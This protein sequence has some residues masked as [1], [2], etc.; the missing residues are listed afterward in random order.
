MARTVLRRVL[1]GTRWAVQ[2]LLALVALAALIAWPWSYAHPGHVQAWRPWTV[3]AERLER[4]WWLGGW[5]EGRV[6]L[7]LHGATFTERQRERASELAASEGIRWTWRAQPGAAYWRV[8]DDGYAW[9]PF[10]F[11]VKHYA[12]PGASFGGRTLSL[13]CWLLALAAGAWPAVSF[14]LFVRRRRRLRRLARAGCCRQCGYDLRA[15]PEPAGAGGS[16]WAVCPECGAG[17]EM[18]NV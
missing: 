2:G 7:G 6:G 12:E 10:R 11:G 13:P 3:G 5:G 17:E 15:T 16:L 9:G 18:S 1:R 14:A 8:L 4:V